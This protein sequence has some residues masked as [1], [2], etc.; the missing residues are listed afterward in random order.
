MNKKN[1]SQLTGKVFHLIITIIDPH[2]TVSAIAAH[3]KT[4]PWRKASRI[5]ELCRGLVCVSASLQF[6]EN[7]SE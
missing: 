4:K 5:M 7:V 6:Y 1:G 3:V 2:I